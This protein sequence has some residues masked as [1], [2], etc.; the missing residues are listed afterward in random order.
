VLAERVDARVEGLVLVVELLLEDARDA[1]E[2]IRSVGR[3]SAGVEAAEIELDERLPT[4]AG[5]V[6]LLELEERLIVGAVDLDDFLP[7]EGRLVG[8]VYGLAPQ[9]GNL[10]VLF[11]LVDRILEGRSAL[12]LDVDDVGP[13]LLAA[14]D[15]LEGVHRLKVG[16]DVE[17]LS[18]RI[19]G[20]VR[21]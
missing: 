20:V 18:P 14:V 12:H 9:L 11:D 10:A 15:R 19:G 5:G 1:P 2:E 4:L 16:A 21:L 3:L 6:E 13:L 7:R 8:L 17:K